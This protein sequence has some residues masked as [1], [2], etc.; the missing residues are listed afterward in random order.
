MV[1][2]ISNFYDLPD[3]IFESLNSFIFNP[4]ELSF[5]IDAMDNKNIV[6]PYW[7]IMSEAIAISSKRIHS[8]IEETEKEFTTFFN[9]NQESFK[10]IAEKYNNFTIDN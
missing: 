10:I 8:S 9:R 7:D 1:K 3:A 6:I 5:L 2:K 4:E